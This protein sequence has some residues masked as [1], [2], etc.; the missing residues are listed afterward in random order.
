MLDISGLVP[1][2]Q[3]SGSQILDL[4]I[5]RALKFYQEGMDGV[6]RGDQ[7][8]SV[9]VDLQRKHITRNGIERIL[10]RA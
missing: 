2:N 5:E 4:T 1:V 6:D 3:R 9:V 8:R 7:Y 10:C